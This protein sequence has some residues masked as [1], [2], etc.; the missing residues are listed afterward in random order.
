MACS[1]AFTC[2]GATRR[3]A[4]GCF[5]RLARKAEVG[6]EIEQIVLDAR[7]HRLD[8]EI[9]RVARMAHR[10][11]REA[12]GAIRLV[13][14]AHRCDARVALRPPRPVAKP[15]LALVAGARVDDVQ[16]DHAAP[17]ARRGGR[18]RPLPNLRVARRSARVH[19]A[20]QLTLRSRP[21]Q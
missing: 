2:D 17:A 4:P 6:A 3:T 10:E 1:S 8:R 7:Q 16:L 5:V 9:G 20:A 18:A 15:R 19:S 12:D 13:D 21:F 14:V 11:Q